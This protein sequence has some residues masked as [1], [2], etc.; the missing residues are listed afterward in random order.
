MARPWPTVGLD[1]VAELRALLRRRD[2]AARQIGL[3]LLRSWTAEDLGAVGAR[4]VLEAAGGSYP[5]LPG[6]HE[7]PAEMM[8][9]LLWDAPTS[10]P[11]T[12]VVRVYLIAGERVRRALIHLLALRCDAD[13]LDGL[14]FIL[15]PEAPA[16]LLASPTT[17]L[18]EP[19]T[20]H[21]DRDRVRALLLAALP[22]SGWSWHAA[23]MLLA[24]E[25]TEPSSIE[26]RGRLMV[27]VGS[28]V[29]SLVEACNRAALTD[30]RA[31][32]GARSEREALSAVLGLL[33][34]LREQ[35]QRDVLAAMLGS[36]DPRVAAMGAVRLVARAQPVAPERLSLIA[37]D[38]VA[39]ADLHDGLRSAHSSDA[40]ALSGIEVAEG[41]LARWLS[42][43]T[44]LGRVPDEMEHVA[45][46][47]GGDGAD[48]ADAV[49]H[50]FR[51]RMNAPHWSS[52]R[53]WMIGAAGGDA[54]SC[55]SAQDEASL[56]DHVAEIRRALT[57][58]PDRRA[59]GAA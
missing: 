31:G 6:D 40:F 51:F 42:A 45:T 11:V 27:G 5:S 13:G 18:L 57:D 24:L 28:C 15:G 32:D 48:D 1:D 54:Y 49:M 36:S 47:P 56:A 59:D 23:A 33:D 7:H 35:D 14:E 43:V 55:Y 20:A 37:R 17:P 19:L 30:P 9:H 44:E 26:N 53:G 41:E 52:A 12:D 25:T 46:V 8:A 16:E 21:P 39:R 50:V 29:V 38:P 4:A 3:A 58:W 22:R 34:E 2:A 10:V